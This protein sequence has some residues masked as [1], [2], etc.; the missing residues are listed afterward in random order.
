MELVAVFVVL[1]ISSALAGAAARGLL[2]LTF[3]LLLPSEP[4][5]INSQLPTPNSQSEELAASA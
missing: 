1:L 3:F 2:A 5:E 4:V